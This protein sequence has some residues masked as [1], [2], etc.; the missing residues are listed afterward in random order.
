MTVGEFLPLVAHNP[1]LD[2]KI[3]ES[4]NTSVIAFDVSGYK[5]L[6]SE[7][8]SRDLDKV[9]IAE[10]VDD[11]ISFKLF[12]KEVPPEPDPD[13]DPDPE[14]PTTDPTDPEDPGTTEPTDPGEDPTTP[15]NGD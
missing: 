14:D 15:D 12:L 8:N 6:N 3:I 5:A 11:S 9:T 13:P 1:K 4:D 7:L 2:I 10:I